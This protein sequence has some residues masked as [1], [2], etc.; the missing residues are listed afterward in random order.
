METNRRHRLECSREDPDIN[1]AARMIL[2]LKDDLR[3]KILMLLLVNDTL[4]FRSI[5]KK[6]KVGY[7]RLDKYLTTMARSGLLEIMKVKVSEDRVYTVYALDVDVKE[8]LAKILETIRC[9]SP[10]MDVN[11]ILQDY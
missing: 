1:M 9:I 2:L 4:S 11:N 5:A 3:I 10:M 6:L 8:Y 7:K